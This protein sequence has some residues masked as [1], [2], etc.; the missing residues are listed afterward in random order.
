MADVP[1]FISRRRLARYKSL[2]RAS[3]DWALDSGGFSELSLFGRWTITPEQYAAEVRR[4]RDGVGRLQFAA[5]MD[6]MCEPF[7]LEKT[8]LSVEEHQARTVEN[9]LRLQEISPDLPWMPVLQGW[10]YNEYERHLRMYRRSGVPLDRL[11]VVGLGSVCRRQHTGMVEELVRDLAVHQNLRLHG[12]G[13]K[14][15]GL[16]R[17]ARYLASADSMAWNM[18]ARF[19]PPLS[20]CEDRHVRCVGCPRYALAWRDRLH[21]CL[22]DPDARK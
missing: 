15:R 14:M 19:A 9:Y 16:S 3:T 4:F 20:K 13:I 5:A 11:P 10:E 1:L 8:G 22:A 6:W 2:P 18:A 17:C 21:G 7:I 12:F